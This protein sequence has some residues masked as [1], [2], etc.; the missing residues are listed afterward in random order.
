MR[1]NWARRSS[2]VLRCVTSRK[3]ILWCYY[4]HRGGNLRYS[5][6]ILLEGL[7]KTMEEL[8]IRSSAPVHVKATWQLLAE[9]TRHNC[10]TVWTL[11][12]NCRA[13][14]MTAGDRGKPVSFFYYFLHFISSL[15]KLSFILRSSV[16][17]HL[18]H[19]HQLLTFI[20]L[21][22]PIHFLLIGVVSCLHSFF[23]SSCLSLFLSFHSFNRSYF[24]P[25][26]YKFSVFS[27]F[28]PSFLPSFVH[29]TSSL[30]LFHAF[31]FLYLFTLGCLYFHFPSFDTNIFLPFSISLFHYWTLPS[32]AQTGGTPMLCARLANA[33]PVPQTWAKGQSTWALHMCLPHAAVRVATGLK[34]WFI[35]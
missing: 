20:S 21:F 3:N 29:I 8:R 13:A 17:F 4:L 27:R 15:V 23:I 7:M 33:S 14:I 28:F 32:F 9:C 31:I 5:A 30:P 25:L 2:G 19:V 34:F 18:S 11:S 12:S 22:L 26:L 1:C 6:G 10:A 16:L 24:H 35:T